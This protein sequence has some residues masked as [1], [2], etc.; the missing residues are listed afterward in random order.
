M[1]LI[2]KRNWMIGFKMPEF[3][4]GLA[5]IAVLAMVMLVE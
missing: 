2:P 3:V 1:T 5:F 4:M